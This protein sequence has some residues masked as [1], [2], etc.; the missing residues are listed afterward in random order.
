MVLSIVGT[1]LSPVN[2]PLTDT[3]L[4]MNTCGAYGVIKY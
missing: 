2:N 3:E 4:E 1:I